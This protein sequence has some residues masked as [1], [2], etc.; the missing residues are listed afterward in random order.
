MK[1]PK[2]EI[3]KAVAVFR[4]LGAEEV[5]VFGS[6]AA[7]QMRSGSDLDFAVLGLPAENF[8]LAVGRALE[9]VRLPIDVIDLADDTPFT[10]HLIQSGKLVRVG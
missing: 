7:N 3:A 9:E 2:E 6:A 8:Y 4:S 5:Y 1:V 10:R